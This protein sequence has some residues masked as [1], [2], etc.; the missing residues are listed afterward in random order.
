MN[1]VKRNRKKKKL[2][3]NSYMYEY[4][5]KRQKCILTFLPMTV[6]PPSCSRLV[7][8]RLQQKVEKQSIL[9]SQC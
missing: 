4:L 7:L 2:N 3:D 8:E 6:F 9:Q 1:Y 5:T